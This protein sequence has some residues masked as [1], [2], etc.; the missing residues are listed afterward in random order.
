MI[1]CRWR[2]F[3]IAVTDDCAACV[4]E[5]WRRLVGLR[6]ISPT[7]CGSSVGIRRADRPQA[8]FRFAQQMNTAAHAVT[9]A[10][11]GAGFQPTG[12]SLISILSLSFE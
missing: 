2:Q 12:H 3:A 5:I 11:A 7:H 4:V 10:H 9:K 8:T 1:V 6:L